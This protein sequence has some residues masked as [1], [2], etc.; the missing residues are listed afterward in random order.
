MVIQESHY[1]FGVVN[2]VKTLQT[3]RVVRPHDQQSV[4]ILTNRQRRNARSYRAAAWRTQDS[5]DHDVRA[6][7][8]QRGGLL[9]SISYASQLKSS[10]SKL[11]Q[12]GKSYG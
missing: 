9:I 5:N 11:V 8:I 12:I 1:T 3:E 6:N 2:Q 7:M 4:M 10:Q